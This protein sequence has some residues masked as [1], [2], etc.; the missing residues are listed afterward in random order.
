MKVVYYGNH[1]FSS[2]QLHITIHC[3]RNSLLPAASA[4]VY[5]TKVKVQKPSNQFDLYFFHKS[6]LKIRWKTETRP[7]PLSLILLKSLGF[8]GFWNCG[9]IHYSVFLPECQNAGSFSGLDLRASLFCLLFFLSCLDEVIS[10]TVH[11]KHKPLLGKTTN[12]TE[13]KHTH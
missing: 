6:G 2:F 10:S 8:S 9:G 7:H 5:K 4:F 13:F 11:R 12:S 3:W 1:C